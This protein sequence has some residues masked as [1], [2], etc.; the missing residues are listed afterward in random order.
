MISVRMRAAVG[1]MA[2]AGLATL[3]AAPA[4]AQDKTFDLKIS[5]WAPATHPLQKA[6]EELSLIHI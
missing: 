5:S 1:A 4:S 6:F 2:A 3:M